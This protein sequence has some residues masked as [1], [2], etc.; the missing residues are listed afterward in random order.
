[1]FVFLSNIVWTIY[2]DFE[3]SAGCAALQNYAILAQP[4]RYL[5]CLKTP[6]SSN[7]A[8]LAGYHECLW[9]ILYRGK[10]HSLDRKQLTVAMNDQRMKKTRFNQQLH[11]YYLCMI[12]LSTQN[13]CSLYVV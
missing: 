2:P 6:M 5:P 3:H 4:F 13:Y 1:M 11:M 8:L 12:A 9:F 10:D 7:K